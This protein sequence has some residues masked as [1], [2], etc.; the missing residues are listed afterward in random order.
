M[1]RYSLKCFDIFSY[2]IGLC[3]RLQTIMLGVL[4]FRV[5]TKNTCIVEASLDKPIPLEYLPNDLDDIP[6]G[7][8]NM[9]RIFETVLTLLFI[10]SSITSIFYVVKVIFVCRNQ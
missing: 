6:G 9:S 2:F 10:T 8:A 4:L 5:E 3:V 1:V 7:F